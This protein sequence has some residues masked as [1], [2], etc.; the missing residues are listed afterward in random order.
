MKYA[1]LALFA[2]G[3]MAQGPD[4]DHPFPNHELP[5]EGWTCQ[6]QDINSSVPRVHVCDCQRMCQKAEDGTE[7]VRED[8]TCKVFCH[9]H[10]CSCEITKCET[11]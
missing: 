8:P 4:P 10:A 6:R 3:I 1:L 2:I 9:P 5:P 11:D 7:S